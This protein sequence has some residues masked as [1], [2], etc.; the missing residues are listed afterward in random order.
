MHELTDSIRQYINNP[1]IQYALLKK[2][3]LWLQLCS[4]LDVIGDAELAIDAYASGEGGQSD[5][6][7]YLSLYGLLQA[8]VL[9]Q[10][11]VQDICEALDIKVDLSDYPKRTQIREIRHA[12]AGHPTKR[13][14]QP[15]SHFIARATMSL[16]GF[17]LLTA[18]DDGRS[19]M[20]PVSV[21]ELIKDQRE[22]VTKILSTVVEDLERRDTAHKEKFKLEKLSA[23]FDNL[24]HPFEKLASACDGREYRPLGLYGLDSV[25]KALGD[26]REALVR[27]GL[28]IETYDSVKY[29]FERLDYPLLQLRAYLEESVAEN[30]VDQP[31][32]Y[33]FAWYVIEHSKRLSDIARAID[34]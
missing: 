7:R 31:T 8:I 16:G 30:P 10:D 23:I 34:E 6:D 29:L 2:L 18:Y 5:G 11:A 25:Q 32:A 17:E 19:K 9:Q 33:I 15:R 20:E 28:E 24:G 14:G 12:A 13:R 21:S 22:Y 3:G 26:F 4:S 27:R 1:R